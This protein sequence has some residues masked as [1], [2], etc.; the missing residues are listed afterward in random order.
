M[1]SL[2]EIIAQFPEVGKVGEIIPLTAGLINIKFRQKIR[3]LAITYCSVS[4]IRFSRMWNFFNT[5]LNV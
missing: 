5:T 1:K 2:N 4:I 3:R